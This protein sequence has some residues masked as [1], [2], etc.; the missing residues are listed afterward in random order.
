[1]A[2]NETQIIAGDLNVVR[3]RVSRVDPSKL[4]QAARNDLI[5]AIRYAESIIR[6]AEARVA[7]SNNL[8]AV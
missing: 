7:A 2:R 8:Q 3:Q 1:M 6:L 5:D 4:D